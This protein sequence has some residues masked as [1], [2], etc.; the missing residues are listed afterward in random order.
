MPRVVDDAVVIDV[1]PIQFCIGF[2]QLVSIG[3]L[4]RWCDQYT[5]VPHSRIVVEAGHQLHVAVCVLYGY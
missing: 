1:W 3:S 5:E 4:F 2:L